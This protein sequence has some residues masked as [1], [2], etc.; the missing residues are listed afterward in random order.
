ML[1]RHGIF[2]RSKDDTPCKACTHAHP[3]IFFAS[4]SKQK[5]KHG[6]VVVLK[7]TAHLTHAAG[8]LHLW[9]AAAAAQFL[10]VQLVPAGIL[11]SR[12]IYY[13]TRPIFSFNLLAY[14]LQCKLIVP[15]PTFQNKSVFSLTFG[16]WFYH[17]KD[18]IQT[19]ELDPG[20]S[21]FKSWLYRS[22]KLKASLD[23]LLVDFGC[24][25][26]NIYQKKFNGF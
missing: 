7:G 13:S 2:R 5:H 16:F 24:I 20:S 11:R 10:M 14:D 26:E 18:K 23:L 17:I 9:Q 12:S 4:S 22:A 3:S 19:K 8:T 21:F 1:P 6:K 25:C 15:S